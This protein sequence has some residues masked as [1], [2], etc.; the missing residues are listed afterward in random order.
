MKA[1][2]PAII[3]FLLLSFCSWRVH[4]DTVER[5][6]GKDKVEIIVYNP[7]GVLI[8]PTTHR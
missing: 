1:T 6:N 2:V 3:G 7:D 4:Q 5:R 8:Q